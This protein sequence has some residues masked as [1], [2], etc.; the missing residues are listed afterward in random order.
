[1][2]SSSCQVSHLQSYSPP[3]PSDSQITLYDLPNLSKPTPLPQ[4]RNAQSFAISQAGLLV[5]GCRKKV[6]V[7]TYDDKSKTALGLGQA[8]EL[9]LPHTPRLILLPPSSDV[10]ECF[11]HLCISPNESLILRITPTK[12]FLSVSEPTPPPVTAAKDEAGSTATAATSG[13]GMNMNALSGIGGYM[14]LGAK[15]KVIA[16]AVVGNEVLVTRDG[17][18]LC[19]R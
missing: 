14:G 5:V 10:A 2:R 8:K 3:N 19:H 1:M 7:Y 12:P 18:V 16:G 11:A 6:L 4:S 9:A 17:E 13:L 15:S